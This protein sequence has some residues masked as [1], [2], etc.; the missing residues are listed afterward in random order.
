MFRVKFCSVQRAVVIPE[1]IREVQRTDLV[2]NVQ[3][4]G[5]VV[6]KDTVEGTCS[7]NKTLAS[8]QAQPNLTTDVF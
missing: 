6:V 7:S 1:I 2:Y 3:L 8:L 4:A 5:A